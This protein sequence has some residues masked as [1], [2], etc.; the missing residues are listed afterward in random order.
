MSW[1]FLTSSTWKSNENF[2]SQNL[3][4]ENRKKLH[5]HRNFGQLTKKIFWR[6]CIFVFI[7]EDWI[8]KK[9]KMNISI[10]VY[11]SIKKSE[12]CNLGIIQ[13][14]IELASV[15]CKNYN[16]KLTNS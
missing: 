6:A 13:K 4:K 12:F 2:G 7:V 15:Y 1:N 3:F 9:K 5:I 11:K 8:E 14:Y 10:N 16:S